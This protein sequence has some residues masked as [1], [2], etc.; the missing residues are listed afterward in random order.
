MNHKH[1]VGTV[2][3]SL[4]SRFLMHRLVI[5][6]QISIDFALEFGTVC[7][8]VDL[9]FG[10]VLFSGVFVDFDQMSKDI[11]FEINYVL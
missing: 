10:R 5:Q 11:S 9:T 3:L 4:V 6:P 7:L 2:A 1:C 8:K